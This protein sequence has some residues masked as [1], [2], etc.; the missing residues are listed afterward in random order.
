MKKRT[1]N[2]I[3]TACVAVVVAAAV[4]VGVFVVRPMVTEKKISVKDWEDFYHEEV[5]LPDIP[6]YILLRYGGATLPSMDENYGAPLPSNRMV[7]PIDVHYYT[8]PDASGEP[9]LTIAKGTE[10]AAYL[11]KE[12]FSVM[13]GYARG[14]YGYCCFPDYQAGW[15]YGIPFTTEDLS[16]GVSTDWESETEKYYVKLSELETVAQTFWETNQ[17]CPAIQAMVDE[18]GGEKEFVHWLVRSSDQSMENS[19]Y[20]DSPDYP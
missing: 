20:F 12:T 9:A 10:V 15:R 18:L 16:Q 4:L 13:T 11:G 5:P 2:L 14:G 3:I 1:R 6:W 8:S 19:G 17:N 7:L